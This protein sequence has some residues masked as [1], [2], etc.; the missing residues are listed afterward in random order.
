MKEIEHGTWGGHRMHKLYK[1]P[2]CADCERAKSE[3]RAKLKIR[4]RLE[5]EK[6]AAERH[7]KV[8]G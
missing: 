5:R 3:R 1:I 8:L 6:R 7:P 4:A 2:M